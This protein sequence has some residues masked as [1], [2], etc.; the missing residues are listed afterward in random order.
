MNNVNPL[1]LI[2]RYEAGETG[3]I[4]EFVHTYQPASYRLA[5]SILDDPAEA[6]EVAQDA[7]VTALDRLASFRGGLS[8]R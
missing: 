3:A 8:S 7:L 6:E 1:R 4:E 5:L 2:Q